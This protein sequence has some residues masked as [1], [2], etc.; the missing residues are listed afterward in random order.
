MI[1]PF[2]EHYLIEVER[3]DMEKSLEKHGVNIDPKG[4]KSNNIGR[5]KQVHTHHGKP[6]LNV[7]DT[8]VFKPYGNEE[9]KIGEEEYLFV[10]ESNIV[11]RIV[12]K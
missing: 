11:G 10:P 12:I 3:S 9:V 6:L 8:V 1:E 4:L 7:G 5:I 2:N